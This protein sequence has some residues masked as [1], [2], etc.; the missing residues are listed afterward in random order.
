MQKGTVVTLKPTFR[1]DT[2]MYVVTSSNDGRTV[3]IRGY[4]T[5]T[6]PEIQA[7]VSQLEEQ[8]TLP[9]FY[10]LVN[11]LKVIDVEYRAVYFDNGDLRTYQEGEERKNAIVFY[12]VYVQQFDKD[13]SSPLW[14]CVADLYSEEE[15][16]EL[17]GL[18]I[19]S[20]I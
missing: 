20:F 14:N 19:S 11:R 15:A 6:H 9:A 4:G 18:L 12:S 13:T 10:P 16:I 8:Y 3:N 17:T 7:A 1:V 2:N 5:A